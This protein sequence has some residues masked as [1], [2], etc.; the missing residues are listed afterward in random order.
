MKNNGDENNYLYSK[1]ERHVHFIPSLIR[2]QT[3]GV[4]KIAVPFKSRTYGWLIQFQRTPVLFH[5]F[6]NQNSH[7]FDQRVASALCRMPKP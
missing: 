4:R 6:I 7:V 2:H 5:V 1:P 3:T